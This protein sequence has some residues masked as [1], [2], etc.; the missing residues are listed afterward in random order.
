MT[1]IT[2]SRDTM[3]ILKNF[4]TISSNLIIREQSDSVM[5]VNPMKTCV[6]QAKIF[7]R[8]NRDIPIYDLGQFLGVLA[9]F[10]EPRIATEEDCIVVSDL[11]GRNRVK[12]RYANPSILVV[13]SKIPPIPD[14]SALRFDLTSADFGRLLKSAAILQNTELAI[15]K[16]A[17]SDVVEVMVTNTASSSANDFTLRVRATAG[18][19][20]T[21][22]LTFKIDN[23]KMLSTDYEISVGDRRICVFEGKVGEVDV[24]YWIPSE[25]RSEFQAG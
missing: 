14:D 20:S 4:A 7:E 19:D 2:L 18:Q 5:T 6:G 1:T 21:A 13:P 11:E 9:L 17:D 22:N 15:R 24:R 25:D 10:D 12:Y 23:L 3:S 16:E 8:F